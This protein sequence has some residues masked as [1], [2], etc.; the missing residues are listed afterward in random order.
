MKISKRTKG[1]KMRKNRVVGFMVLLSLIMGTHCVGE[2]ILLTPEKIAKLN[3]EVTVFKRPNITVVDGIDKGR[4]YFLQL[5]VKKRGRSKIV[6]AFLDKEDGAVYIGHRYEKSGEKVAFPKTAKMIENIKKGISFSYG[7]GK[8]DLYIVTDPECPY[9]KRF[10]QQAQG[11]LNEYRVHVIL[12][13]LSFHKKAPAMVEWIMHG[14]D[15]VQKHQR[16][17]EVMVKNSKAY[18][19]FIGKLGKAFKYTDS[20]K[21]KIDD[22]IAAGKALGARGTPSVYN[23]KFTKIN[24]KS[25]VIPKKTIPI[26]PSIKSSSIKK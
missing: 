1:Y 23:E 8:K 18:E 9:C 22:A 7:T 15:D 11:K 2:E 12:Y 17:E 21:V 14:K 16:M 4:Y 26:K 10:E 6:N 13:P 3:K 5:S 19:A 24:W 20:I 25:L